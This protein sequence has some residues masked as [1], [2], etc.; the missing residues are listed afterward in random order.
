CAFL[1]PDAIP[2]ELLGEGADAL[3]PLLQHTVHDALALDGAIKDLR[4]FSLL[5]R[6]HDSK[7]LSIH[8]LVQAVIKDGMDENTQRQWAERTVRVVNGAFP[9]GGILATWPTCQR[10]LPHAH[11]CAALIEQWDLACAEAA[12]LLHQTGHYLLN[13]GQYQQAEVFLQAAL[14]I[15]RGSV[16]PVHSQMAD[17]LSH[18]A[19]LF[20]F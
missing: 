7:T 18:L 16:A 20:H 1:H 5:R 11:V 17:L 14:T 13:R 6:T 19:L 12:R 9:D 15:Y 10:Y 3:G 4:R 8:R 2:E